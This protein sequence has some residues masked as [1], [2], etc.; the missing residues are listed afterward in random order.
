MPVILLNYIKYMVRVR[1]NLTTRER[2]IRGYLV[3][4]AT[5]ITRTAAATTIYYYYYYYADVVVGDI[6][7]G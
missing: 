5:T 7:R 4:S 2:L 1:V 6:R 3:S